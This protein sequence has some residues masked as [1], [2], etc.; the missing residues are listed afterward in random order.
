MNG[1][2]KCLETYTD[3]DYGVDFLC[4]EVYEYKNGYMHSTEN[5]T[6]V[7]IDDEELKQF[8]RKINV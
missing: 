5:G 1:K 4:G 8:W 7:M 3:D 6:D 2:Y